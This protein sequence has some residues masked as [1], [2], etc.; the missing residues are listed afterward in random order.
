MREAGTN[1]K[2]WLL[3]KLHIWLLSELPKL[4][5]H[6]QDSTATIQDLEQI[7]QAPHAYSSRSHSHSTPLLHSPVYTLLTPIPAYSWQSI[8]PARA[9][10]LFLSLPPPIWLSYLFAVAPLLHAYPPLQVSSSR[11]SAVSSCS[12]HVLRPV[13][14]PLIER[15]PGLRPRPHNF[16]LPDKDDTNFIPRLLYVW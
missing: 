12:N 14:P 9:S 6:T 15:R 4:R 5:S 7:I 2:T 1:S 8:I 13:F 11:S 3:L 10:F 16:T